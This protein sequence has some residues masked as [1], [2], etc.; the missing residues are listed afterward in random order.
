M[1]IFLKTIGNDQRCYKLNH[2]ANVK[3]RDMQ[4]KINKEL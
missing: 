3:Q 1:I 4:R 2:S